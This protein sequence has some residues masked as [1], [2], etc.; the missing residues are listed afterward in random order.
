MAENKNMIDM[1]LGKA[2][3]VAAKEI[4]RREKKRAEIPFETADDRKLRLKKRAELA[5]EEENRH[6][7]VTRLIE[8]EDWEGLKKFD[9]EQSKK[10]SF[11]DQKCKCGYGRTDH[12]SSTFEWMGGACEKSGCKQFEVAK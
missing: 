2:I 3:G 11:F 10:V 5:R 8:S 9:E 12:K 4:K 7:R 6:K 1:N